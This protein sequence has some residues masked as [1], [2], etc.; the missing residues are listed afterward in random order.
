MRQTRG[1]LFFQLTAYVV[2]SRKIAGTFGNFFAGRVPASSRISRIYVVKFPK[3]PALSGTLENLFPA[4]S[5]SIFPQKCRN[6]GQLSPIKFS[7]RNAGTW[8]NL[9]HPIFPQKCGNLGKP[10]NLPA[11]PQM[12]P[13]AY[14]NVQQQGFHASS[15]IRSR[16]LRGKWDFWRR[17][18][19]LCYGAVSYLISKFFEYILQYRT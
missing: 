2:P 1:Q 6:L 10:S 14:K 19:G 15:G 7:L 13:Q 18:S 11:S 9:L 17:F 16:Y 8:D 5:C 4:F 3:V 12:A